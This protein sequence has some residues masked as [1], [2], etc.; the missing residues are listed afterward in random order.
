MELGNF[1]CIALYVS[2]VH[3]KSLQGGEFK[4]EAECHSW[5][6]DLNIRFKVLESK[7]YGGIQ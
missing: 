6:K 3:G 2:P 4:T 7:M 1:C 5:I